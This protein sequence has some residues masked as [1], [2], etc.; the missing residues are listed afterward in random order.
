[1]YGTT[2]RC[3][4]LKQA[5]QSTVQP[6]QQHFCTTSYLSLHLAFLWQCWDGALRWPQCFLRTRAGMTPQATRAAS[7]HSVQ[8]TK[9]HFQLHW[10]KADNTVRKENFFLLALRL[11]KLCKM[12]R[13]Y[14]RKTGLYVYELYSTCLNRHC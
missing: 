6:A 3:E 14:A 9:M 10:D 13:A 1:M 12:E 11:S 2:G 7:G 5:G 8:T 4:Q